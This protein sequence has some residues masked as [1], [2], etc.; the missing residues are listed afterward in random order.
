MDK[1]D[2]KQVEQIGECQIRIDVSKNVGL[3][4]VGGVGGWHPT[5]PRRGTHLICETSGLVAATCSESVT[6]TEMNRGARFPSKRAKRAGCWRNRGGFGGEGAV[7]CLLAVQVVA[8]SDRGVVWWWRV[9]RLEERDGVLDEVRVGCVG[10]VVGL[11][12]G[13]RVGWR[14]EAWERCQG[15]HGEP[16]RSWE[17]SGVRPGGGRG[18]RECERAET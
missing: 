15:R 6:G 17:F 1:Q 9:S 13:G 16:G 10:A 7:R 3:E 14:Q 4:T 2:E 12:Q 5:P 18:M 8:R 11:R